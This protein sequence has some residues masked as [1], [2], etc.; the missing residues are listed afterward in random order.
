MI[1]FFRGAQEKYFSGDSYNTTYQDALYFATDKGVL[2]LNG[3][4]YGSEFPY[5]EVELVDGTT[6]KLTYRDETLG[7]KEINLIES[8]QL[9]TAEQNGLMSKEYAALLDQLG[10]MKDNEEFGKVDG[11]VEGDKMLSIN[12]DKLISSTL[13]IHYGEENGTKYIYLLG[14]AD[15]SE[16]AVDG[17]VVIGK[18][19]AAP[20][21]ADGMLSAVE[22][23]TNEEGK[24]GIEFTWNINDG[25]GLKTDFVPLDE[26]IDV[27]VAGNGIAIDNNVI[28]IKLDTVAT[29][30]LLSVSANGIGLESVPTDATVLQ[31]EIV[32]AGLSGTLGTGNYKNGNTIPAGTSIYTILQNI[33]CK[34]EYPSAK[35]N[36]SASLSSAYANPTFQLTSSGTTVEVGTSVEASAITGYDPTPTTKGRTYSGFTY[37]YSLGYGDNQ[38]TKTGQPATVNVTDVEL[39]SGT[40]TVKREYTGFGTPT[41]ETSTSSVSASSCTL[42]AKNLVVKE[43]SN[44]VKVTMSGPGHSGVIASSPDYYIVSNLGNTA[45]DKKVAGVAEATP[46]IASATAGSS[47]L[48]VTG[49]YKYYIGYAATKPSTTADI[50][51]LT[52]FSGWIADPTTH[53]SNSA[54]IGTLPAGNTM[55]IAVPST[56]QLESITNTLGSESKASF[57]TTASPAYTVEYE[58]ADSSKVNYTVYNMASGADW[59]YKY[60]KISKK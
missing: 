35:V 26:L 43:G 49:G 17:R 31:K 52:T 40:Y 15:D 39:V 42:A 24:K 44:S 21:I 50:K 34:E 56:Y 51:K 8:L 13:D 53:G 41:A 54:V 27:Y 45:S 12:T 5:K 25:D 20:F 3:V 60:I 11:I 58:L 33:L 7:T 36:Q 23:K 16:N 9:A 19:D 6:L 38:E 59:E 14:K 29:R 55:C 4:D 47:T 28:S 1:K 22:F 10:Q 18:I 46:S 37:G 48:S 32:V 57:D 2:Y 30:N